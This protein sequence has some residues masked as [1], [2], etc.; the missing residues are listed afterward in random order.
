MQE[1]V[2]NRTDTNGCITI[3]G[4][5]LKVYALRKDMKLHQLGIGRGNF[6]V[7][8]TFLLKVYL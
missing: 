4:V 1:Q 6:L 5:K 2:V 3:D 8:E 7:E